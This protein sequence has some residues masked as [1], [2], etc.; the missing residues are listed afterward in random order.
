[1]KHIKNKIRS[2]F[3]FII[4]YYSY[5][6][7]FIP[8]VVLKLDINK[9]R[10]NQKVAVILS[11]FSSLIVA[12]ILVIIYRKELIKEFKIFKDKFLNN[13]DI[14]LI[15]WLTGIVV[16]VIANFILTFVL[17]SDG[18]DNENAI[19]ELIK[20]VPLIMAVNVCLLAPFNEEMVFRKALK[21]ITIN[22]YL[23]VLLSF[24]FFGG[25]H[26]FS[27]A[28]TLV[29]YLYIIPYGAL[30]ASF[31]IAYN[32]TNTIYTSLSYHMIH[33]TIAILLST[34]I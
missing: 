11:T 16:M 13:M 21:D 20:A 1:M 31:A 18:A 5:L 27:S 29:D 9:L 7:Q 19:Q 4:F 22:K 28:K 34:L 17:K 33:N 24:L 25:A 26:V 14:G 23:F 12:I 2:I 6:L 10:G 32:K 15:C 8:I 30:G 3:V